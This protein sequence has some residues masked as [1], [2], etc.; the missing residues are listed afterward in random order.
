MRRTYHCYWLNF[1]CICRISP[2]FDI[3]GH[4]IDMLSKSL[5][6]FTHAIR[7]IVG[8][9]NAYI[10][11]HTHICCADKHVSLYISSPCQI[12]YYLSLYWLLHD[13]LFFAPNLQSNIC[14][15]YVEREIN[16]SYYYYLIKFIFFSLISYCFAF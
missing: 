1:V 9:T 13:T 8:Y 7:K 2:A 12:N 5:Y 4:L 6:I 11:I 3:G 16:H 14:K 10:Y 15:D